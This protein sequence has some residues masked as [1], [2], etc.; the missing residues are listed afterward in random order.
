MLVCVDGDHLAFDDGYLTGFGLA[1]HDAFCQS[2][3]EFA[4][5]LE[6]RGK[7]SPRLWRRPAQE[8]VRSLF[9]VR[10]P[11]ADLRSLTA[12][13][14]PA[15]QV[16][17][18][19]GKR[20]VD[21]RSFG[22]AWSPRD[23]W[24]PT[25]DLVAAEGVFESLLSYA[26]GAGWPVREGGWW[27][28]PL[29]PWEPVAHMPHDGHVYRSRSEIVLAYQQGV[30]GWPRVFARMRGHPIEA[31]PHQVALTADHVYGRF[32]D[33]VA[34]LPRGSIRGQRL[35]DGVRVFLFGRRT[36]L[37]L[38]DEERSPVLTWL[39]RQLPQSVRGG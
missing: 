31:V 39:E 5:F 7:V 10:F 18:H 17:W 8:I 30:R 2:V 34:R 4:A 16:R 9:K 19:V 11:I 3:D 20:R 25:P 12:T 26:R 29:V 33:H 15:M 38:P 27:R 24:A 13:R 21:E 36:S 22:S 1:R 28:E 35:L 14:W 23:T 37:V 32:D 6:R